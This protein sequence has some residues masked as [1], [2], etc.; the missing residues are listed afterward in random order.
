MPSASL[1]IRNVLYYMFLVAFGLV[2]L[3]PLLWLLLASVKPSNEIFA[4]AK[5][6]PSQFVFS[7]Y[8]KG[9]VGTGQ[10][11]FADF[12]LNSFM[13]VVPVVVFTLISSLLVAYGFARFTFPLKKLFFY[14]MISV[15]MLP[16]SVVI[17]PRYLLF[18]DLGWINTYLPFIVPAL[19]ATSSF[20]V[21]MFIQ[22]FRGLPKELDESAIIDGCGSL[23]ILLYILMPLCKPAIISATIFQFIW[24]WNDFFDQLIYINSVTKYTVSLGLRMS[25]DTSTHVEWNQLLAM[26]IIAILPCVI[27]FFVSQKYF[28]EGIATTGLK[29]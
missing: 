28:V 1:R 15:L 7:S 17:I 26:S 16:G 4:S 2:M 14:A 24:T 8:V 23:K 13:L 19:F 6:W 18:R 20:F 3:Y 25:L 12:T 29:G 10:M 21:F 9:W 22:F 27:V 5:L 11:G